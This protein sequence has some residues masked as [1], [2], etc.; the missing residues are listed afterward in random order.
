MMIFEQKRAVVYTD[1]SK[2]CSVGRFYRS[3]VTALPLIRQKKKPRAKGAGRIQINIGVNK[4]KQ[5]I[6]SYS[7]KKNLTACKILNALLTTLIETEHF[8]ISSIS[9]PF[10][11]IYF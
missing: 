2:N 10:F 3:S 4:K 7:K 9:K 6:G 11:S 5:H 1:L 8:T